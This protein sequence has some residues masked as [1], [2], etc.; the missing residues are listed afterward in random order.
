MDIGVAFSDQTIRVEIDG[1]G[2]VHMEIPSGDTHISMAFPVS[3]LVK[4][5]AACN[6]ALSK[7]RVEQS[8]KVERLD[9]WRSH[10]AS[11]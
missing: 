3:Q 9:A 5:V 8:G 11:S 1:N 4:N 6:A 7:W 2:I 10:A